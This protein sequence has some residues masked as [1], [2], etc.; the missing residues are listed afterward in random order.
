MIP[1][2]EFLPA[3]LRDAWKRLAEPTDTDGRRF[4]PA[5]VAHVPAPVARWLVHSIVP[6][7]PLRA[8]A[9][10]SMHGEIRIGRW[11]PFTASQILTPNG[12]IWAANAGRLPMRVRGFDRHTD[13]TGEMRWRLFG[14][15]PV[16]AASGPDITRS[17]AGRLAAEAV[18]LVP[19]AALA[20]D[21]DWSLL[22]DRRA[23]ATVTRG[24]FTHHV[25]IEVDEDGALRSV[26]LPRWGNPDKGPYQDHIFGVAFDRERTADGYTVP[27]TL[28]AGWWYGTERWAEGEF[29]RCEFDQTE[30]F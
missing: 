23:T 5:A 28:R 7:T 8:G 14:L 15:V 11:Q 9:R 6:G 18:T 24:G 2:P 19:G 17:A 12:F 16:V 25:T 13:G 30:F 21:V 27:A 26:T 1:C 20:P 4:D 22:D 10:L 3:E 29:F